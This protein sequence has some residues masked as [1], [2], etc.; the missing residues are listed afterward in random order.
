MGKAIQ[1]HW[2]KPGWIVLIVAA[3]FLIAGLD[4]MTKDALKVGH[5]LRTIE[6]HST[7]KT[8]KE[9]TAEVTET[10]LNAY[11]AHRIE[12]ENASI[13]KS[14]QITLLK[15]NHVKGLI[16][17]DSKTLKLASLLGENLDF[18][19]KGILHSIDGR[20]KME[21]ISLYLCGQ[22]VNPQV[23]DFVLDTAA[24]GYGVDGRDEKGWYDLP[25][26]MKTIEIDKQRLTLTY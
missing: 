13:I 14:I 9:K 26:G 17:F 19:F 25:K 8:A 23:L 12:Q 20:A 21:F 15:H 16:R 24:A 6:R 7:N 1:K 11:I 3:L 10:E 5:I 18:D 22:P 4:P 2:K